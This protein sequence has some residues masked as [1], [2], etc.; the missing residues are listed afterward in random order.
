MGKVVIYRIFLSGRNETIDCETYSCISSKYLLSFAI[1][2]L[3]YS[4]KFN[5]YIWNSPIHRYDGMKRK[6]DEV[7]CLD[8]VIF[9]FEKK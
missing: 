1:K 3:L 2:E 5:H 4:C 9:E 8:I 6:I 7:L